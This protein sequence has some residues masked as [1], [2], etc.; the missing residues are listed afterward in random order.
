AGSSGEYAIQVW[1]REVGSTADYDA[2]AG[3]PF[4]LEP[5]RLLIISGC[6]GD[7]V[8]GGRSVS[9]PL[10]GA[11]PWTYSMSAS[12]IEDQGSW[13]AAFEIHG[14]PWEWATGGFEAAT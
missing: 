14:P 3:T 1:V 8:S 2:W 12:A 13:F 6:A 7:P 9:L 5:A 4:T 11:N 10:S